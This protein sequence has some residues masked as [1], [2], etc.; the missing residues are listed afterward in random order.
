VPLLGRTGTGWRTRLPAMAAFLAV[1]LPAGALLAVARLS[2]VD[3]ERAE[4]LEDAAERADRAFVLARRGVP[5]GGPLEMLAN[6]PQ[7]RGKDVYVQYCTS[8]HVL[9]EWGDRDAPDHTGFASE[10]WI[11]ALLHDP[12]A[13]HFFGET[14]IDEMP[15]Q[16]DKGEEALRGA[17]AFLHSL[18][19]DSDDEESPR[20]DP[21][22]VSQGKE[23][24][25][26]KCMTCHLF[27]GDGD[28]LGLGG[29][30]L[31][32]YG[33]QEWI[34]RQTAD[35]EAHYGELNE[36]PAFGDQ[37]SEHDI[38]MVAAFLRLQRTEKPVFPAEP[39]EPGKGD[40]DPEKDD[41]EGSGS[42]AAV[43]APTR[44]RG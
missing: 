3:E 38:E 5:P 1:L 12:D 41:A 13:P 34:V 6:D 2:P 18:G 36:M 16:S 27:E 22:L 23:L 19:I 10:A 9:G 21:T 15:S 25:E 14:P 8:C 42:S 35:P 4:A 39:P 11:L 44:P 30:D 28:F 20:P 43:P 17:A 32:G 33:S 31:T 24:W 26:N 7:T 37:L 29:P 40:A